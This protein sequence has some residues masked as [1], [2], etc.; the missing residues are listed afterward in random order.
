MSGASTV[1]RWLP[2]TLACVVVVACLAAGCAV[3]D[4]A[5]SPT[6]PAPAGNTTPLTAVEYV[7]RKSG[8]PPATGS[9]VTAPALVMR[10]RGVTARIV[11]AAGN[12]VWRASGSAP[13]YGVQTS[14]DGRRVVTYAGNADFSVRAVD[15]MAAATALPT[16]P[17][18]AG[19]SAF[20]EWHWLDAQHLLGIAELPA[21]GTGAD[22]TAAE[23]ESQSPDATVLAIFDL[24]NGTLHAVQV[25]DGLPRVFTIEAVRD[26]RIRLQ[27][28]ATE[29]AV[30]A[31]FDAGRR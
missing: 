19:A 17:T 3:A 22:M 26:G 23:R 14:P 10:G 29:P 4:G 15:D 27:G 25:A 21:A 12:D 30:W 16:R 28:E 5:Q 11:D 6:A 7:L 13:L 1:N 18:V 31:E 24:D 2:A 9:P 20:G 8:A